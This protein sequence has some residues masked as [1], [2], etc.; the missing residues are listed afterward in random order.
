MKYFP[1]SSFAA[2]L[3]IILLAVLSGLFLFRI[4]LTSDK[5]YSISKQSKE[6]MK[7][8]DSP[9]KATVYLTGDLNAGFLRLKK[10]TA[11]ILGELNAYSQ[12]K[13]QI[14]YKNPSKENTEENTKMLNG[15]LEKRGITATAV[16]EKDKEGKI[17][18][19]DVFPWVELSFR[20]KTVPVNLL[21][22]N[23]ALSG[24]ENLNISIENLEFELT[25]AIRR[26]TNKTI[27]KIAFLEGHGELTEMETHDISRSLSRYFQIDRGEIGT[28]AN[29]LND[30]KAVIIAKPTAPFSEKDKF[31][32][33][34]YLMNGGA[35]LWLIDGVR[36]SEQSLAES[37]NS[38]AV[39][40]ELNL[41]DMLFR[42]GVRINPAL[43]QDVQSTLMP[44]NVAP[45]GQKPQFEPMPWVYSPLLLTSGQHVASRNISPVRARFAS[46]AELVGDDENTSKNIIL[47]SSA[48][49][50]LLQIP[51][52][53][54]VT[55]LP[56]VKNDNYFN[57]SYIPVG[58]SIEGVF[59]SV[60]A[61]RMIP[62]EITNAA[63]IKKASVPTRQIIIADGDII[64]ND[65]ESNGDSVEALPLGFDCYTNQLFGNKDLIIN[66]ILY[67]TDKNGQMQLRSRNIP[68]RLLNK[69]ITTSLLTRWQIIN[70]VLPLILLLLTGILYDQTRKRKY[71]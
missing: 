17:I 2:A 70:V 66:S 68:M 36:L 30:Y 18:Q 41:D 62:P 38:P 64:R 20:G 49:S 10:S 35:L 29:V 50:H 65:I 55:E 56:D 32:L 7:S 1:K 37:G 9:V 5:R 46:S 34:Q 26:L 23:P 54:S 57:V 45:A 42:Y 63:S 51:A 27:G 40:F 39:P 59:R 53:I 58:V 33:D 15:E 67:L 71:R 19:K 25:D 24:E 43:V 22:N 4:D 60:F 28:D 48:K 14:G 8:V 21:K 44:V 52:G 47:A 13:I 69:D 16:F 12:G 11:D 3:V 6:L 31:I 61:N